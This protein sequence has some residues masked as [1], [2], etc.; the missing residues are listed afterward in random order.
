MPGGSVDMVLLLLVALELYVLIGSSF[1]LFAMSED[2]EKDWMRSGEAAVCAAFPVP[3]SH[4]GCLG[5]RTDV[6]NYSILL[7]HH[8]GRVDLRRLV[9]SLLRWI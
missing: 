7:S 5:C 4:R 9:C 8:L 2:G 1:I 6:L 3:L